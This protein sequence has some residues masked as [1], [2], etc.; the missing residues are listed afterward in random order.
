MKQEEKRETVGKISS[1]LLAK[2]PVQATAYE[3]GSEMSKT[4][5]DNLILC[6][7]RGKKDI[8]TDFFIVVL[9]KKEKLM[10]N[11]LRH[12][13]GYRYTCPTPNYDQ[14]VYKYTLKND[15]IEFIWVI[16]DRTICWDYVRN[17]ELVPPDQYPLLRYV[18]EFE[19]GTL[20]RRAKELNNEA[21]L[22]NGIVIFKK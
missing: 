3:L 9:T 12:F 6:A 22:T 14:A 5:A 1:D 2:E 10:P 15:Q 4:Y 19:D 13:F 17:R 8:D 18:L 20:T 21:D 16:P 7:E 11:V